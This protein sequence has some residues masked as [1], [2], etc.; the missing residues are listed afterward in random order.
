[1]S[2]PQTPCE[3]AIER[4]QNLLRWRNLWTILLFAF[5]SSVII[6]LCIAILFFLRTSWIAGAVSTLG[7]IASSIGINWVVSRRT[8]AKEEEEAGYAD[9]QSVCAPLPAPLGDP[10]PALPAEAMESL[11]AQAYANREKHKLFGNII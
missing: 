7:T 8:D 9:V 2:V 6:F 1:M 10:T 4:H 3:Y 5:G 11:V